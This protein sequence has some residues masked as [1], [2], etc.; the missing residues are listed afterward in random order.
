LS[1]DHKPIPF[2]VS[3]FLAGH[4]E[5]SP[6]GHWVAYESTE[7][8]TYEIYVQSFPAPGTKKVVTIGGGVQ[9]RW[10][11]DGK[12]IFYIAPDAT[13]MAVPMSSGSDI[14][15]G[16][17]VSLFKTRMVNGG[18]GRLGALSRHE[19]DVLPDGQR[20]IINTAPETATLPITVLVNWPSMLKR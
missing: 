16:K 3:N 12:E 15:V 13:L 4:A 10:R 9:P 7:S 14:E 8:G 17:P 11:R 18:F 2:Q 5:I 1:G 19:Y 20:F 6:D